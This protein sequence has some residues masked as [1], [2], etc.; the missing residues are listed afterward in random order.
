MCYP[1][2][3]NSYILSNCYKNCNVSKV[4]GVAD[5]QYLEVAELVL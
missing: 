1:L 5:E 3:I 2:G 4:L